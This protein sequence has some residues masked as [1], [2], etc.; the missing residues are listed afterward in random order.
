MESKRMNK[1]FAIVVLFLAGLSQAVRA[2]SFDPH[3]F[4]GPNALRKSHPG[5]DLADLL[6]AGA[7]ELPQGFTA[8]IGGMAFLPDG[9][10]AV[11]D[12]PNPSA[13]PWKGSVWLLTGIQTGD[14][15]QV[16]FARF[17]DNLYG[18]TGL[19]VVNG[20]VYVID[21]NSLKRLSDKDN[22]GTAEV[23]EL[24]GSWHQNGG[25]PAIADLAYHGGFFYSAFGSSGGLSVGGKSVAGGMLK[26]GMD[27]SVERLNTGFRNTGGGGVNAQG[28]LFAT[29]NQGEW[30]PS[31]KLIHA[32]KG[33][34]YGYGGGVASPPAVW[35]PAG[36]M[37]GPSGDASRWAVGLSP[38]TVTPIPTGIF[39]GQFLVGDIR[40]GNVHRVNVEKIE[41]EYQGGLVHFSGGF[42]AG[43]YRMA[44]GPDGS[45]YLGGM[46]GSGY[47]WSWKDNDQSDDWGL[48]RM[49]PNANPVFEIQSV[50]AK[51]GGFE[52]AFTLPV[53]VGI[54]AGN[55]KAQ[56]WRYV[57][58]G[59]YGGPQVDQKNLAITSVTASSDRKKLFLEIPGLEA[60]RVV[61]LELDS[62]LVTSDD[63]RKPWTAEAWYTL[64]RLSIERP[65]LAAAPVP[66]TPGRI[67]ANAIPGGAI[68]IQS[69]REGVYGIRDARGVLLEKGAV[70]AY[71][72]AMTRLRFKPGLY[73]VSL[74]GEPG[75]RV[76]C[77]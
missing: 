68:R 10:L 28:D 53:K 75:L 18:P 76:A 15:S 20:E 46:G 64:N 42:R 47:T 56:S 59:A 60:G 32:V 72:T 62:N 8:H 55:F 63:G 66:A 24:T 16:K 61:H 25:Q 4:A 14:R 5:F 44:W 67:W 40:Y 43:I 27:G 6:P 23:T 49:K 69:D 12:F 1:V 54:A 45:L 11:C 77:P 29:D 17:T 74:N 70:K 22:N 58:T 38:S 7:N 65:T 30:V 34:H 52:L 51:S 36:V 2:Q 50:S 35:I 37:S 57:A 13:Q 39:A 9:R 73:F 31:N 26:I 41:G 19:T 33:R 3:P 21:A 71:K 48:Y